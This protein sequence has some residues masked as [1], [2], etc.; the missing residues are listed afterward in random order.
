MAPDRHTP[1]SGRVARSGFVAEHGS[2]TYS[3]L[4]L[5]IFDECVGVA[6]CVALAPDVFELN[7]A[8]YSTLRLSMLPAEAL[9]RVRK[10]AQSCPTGAIRLIER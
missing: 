1:G 2:L 3:S 6:Q 8:G 4:K 10:A 5:E 7:E 9:E